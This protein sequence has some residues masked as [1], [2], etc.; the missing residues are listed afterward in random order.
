MIC[1]NCGNEVAEGNAFCTGC[2]TP[3]EEAS[4]FVDIYDA[5]AQE[6]PNKTMGTL[7]LVCG[8]V[9]LAYPALYMISA[10]IGCIPVI[11]LIF[12]CSLGCI[13]GPLMSL[14]S[15]ASPLCGV[16]GI[17]FGIIAANAAKQSGCK[18]TSGSTGLLLSIIGLVASV[19]ILVIFTLPSL[20]S[21]L[22]P[23]IFLILAPLGI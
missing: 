17:I 20:L 9:S 7:A 8:F 5:P 13:M 22:L 12:G 23:L 21:L 18:D 19:L 6:S 15:F 2:G 16:A 11:N 1:K 14:L 3:L 10:F 4:P